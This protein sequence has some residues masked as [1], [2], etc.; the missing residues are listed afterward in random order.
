MRTVID[1]LSSGKAK[2]Y[3]KIIKNDPKKWEGVTINDALDCAEKNKEETHVYYTHFK[4]VT[5]KRRHSD[6]T[7]TIDIMYWCFLMYKA[8][9]DF[10]GVDVD[11]E[12]HNGK[13]VIG[14]LLKNA[15][16]MLPMK[17]YKDGKIKAGAAIEYMNEGS[18]L[19]FSNT[20]YKKRVADLHKKYEY[21]T[22]EYV[23]KN[24]GRYA[25]EGMCTFLYGID[26]VT[27]M[28]EDVYKSGISYHHYTKNFCPKLREE[29][30]KFCRPSILVYSYAE[31]LSANEYEFNKVD[32]VDYI[33]YTDHGKSNYTINRIDF[34]KGKTSWERNKWYKWNPANTYD[35]VIYRDISMD[36]EDVYGLIESATSEHGINVHKHPSSKSIENENI[37]IANHFRKRGI[38]YD[39]DIVKNAS[40]ELYSTKTDMAELTLIVYNNNKLDRNLLKDIWEDFMRFGAVRDQPSFRYT[41]FRNNLDISSFTTLPGHVPWNIKSRGADT[42][43]KRTQYYKPLTNQDVAK[44]RQDKFKK[45]YGY[46]FNKN[47]IKTFEEK[48]EWFSENCDLDSLTKYVDK[49]DVRDYAKGVDGLNVIPLLGTYDKFDDIDL[50]SLPDKFIIKCNHDSGSTKVYERGISDVEKLR[51]FFNNKMSKNYYYDYWY[52]PQYAHIT[53]KII[54]EKFMGDDLYDYKF[55]CFDGKVFCASIQSDTFTKIR[56]NFFDRDFNDLK[57]IWRVE[58]PRSERKFP[59]PDNYDELVRIAEKLAEPFSF[60]RVDLYNIDGKIFFGELTFTPGNC[61]CKYNDRSFDLKMGSIY[62]VTKSGLRMAN[63]QK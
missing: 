56:I 20:V 2:L 24:T 19:C 46:E 38:P 35:Y 59:K 58:H 41:I 62:N 51:E 47:N 12:L 63:G 9:F 27:Y 10:D 48:N 22:H 11:S 21:V 6:L 30:N 8:L 25:V 44:I 50:D 1:V 43:I 61:R 53:P 33:L 57:D 39:F 17:R 31:N 16:V 29:F 60:V 18:Y 45:F 49:I 28:T 54:V 23:K 40:G 26:N 32:G 13:T 3:Y 4:G 37:A 55:Y 15:T 52:E 14:L 7:T 5:L 34:K 42:A 36:I